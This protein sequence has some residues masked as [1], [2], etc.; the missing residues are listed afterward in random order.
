[1]IT[2]KLGRETKVNDL[3]VYPDGKR[4]LLVSEVIKITPKG[5]KVL[6]G[7]IEIYKPKILL[8]SLSFAKQ[9]RSFL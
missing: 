7:K 9:N 2:D 3:V 5:I 8:L 1:M 6:N 4:D